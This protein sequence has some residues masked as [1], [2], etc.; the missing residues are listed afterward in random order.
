MAWREEFMVS[1]AHAHR[2]GHA[3]R[4]SQI[5]NIEHRTPNTQHRMV[6]SAESSCVAPFRC[7]HT[8]DENSDQ[9]FGF[10]QTCDQTRIPIHLL[11]PRYQ[12]EPPSRF[13]QL[14]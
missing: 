8:C 2:A 3:K 7:P 12:P 9:L 14:L 5:L 13:A 10:S 4:P 1:L 11:K 6:F